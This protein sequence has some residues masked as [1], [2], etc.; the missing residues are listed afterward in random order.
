MTVTFIYSASIAVV[1]K[2]FV[3]DDDYRELVFSKAAKLYAGW[4]YNFSKGTAIEKDATK[5]L[6]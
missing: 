5:T 6:S 4:N 3:F 1:E 2:D